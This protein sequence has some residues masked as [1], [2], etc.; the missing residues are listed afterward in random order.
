MPANNQKISPFTVPFWWLKIVLMGLLSLFFLLYG[1]ETLIGAYSLK[2][3]MEF[4]MYFFS[5]SFMILV[6]SV[7][8]IFSFFKIYGRLKARGEKDDSGGTT[9]P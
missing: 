9:E 4:I 8:A 1:I 2:N 5:A 3:P 6:S 7:G